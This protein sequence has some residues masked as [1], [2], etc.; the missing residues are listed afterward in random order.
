MNFLPKLA[1][2][3]EWH[4]S[5][6]GDIWTKAQDMHAHRAEFYKDL[7]YEVIRRYFQYG[8]NKEEEDRASCKTPAGTLTSP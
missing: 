7:L 5:F 1:S 8:Q 2:N 6:G 4:V 3:S